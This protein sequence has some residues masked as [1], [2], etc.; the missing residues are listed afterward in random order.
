VTLCD[1]DGRPRGIKPAKFGERFARYA[2]STSD[3]EDAQIAKSRTNC[4]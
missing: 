1:A 4:V 3:V 2:S